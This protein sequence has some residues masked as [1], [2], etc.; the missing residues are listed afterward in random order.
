[1]G[2]A[3]PAKESQ[4]TDRLKVELNHRPRQRGVVTGVAGIFNL[5]RSGS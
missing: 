5:I 3:T 1:M 2:C 4:V